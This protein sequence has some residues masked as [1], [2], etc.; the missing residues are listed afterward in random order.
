MKLEIG[1]VADTHGLVRDALVRLL[2]G[3]EMILHAGDVG[4]LDVLDTLRAIAPVQAV[5]GNVDPP[6]HPAMPLTRELRLGDRQIVLTHGHELGRP[7]SNGLLG[8][9][10]DADIII[11]G[12]THQAGVWQVDS[13]VVINPGAAGPRR[14]GVTPSFARLTIDAGTPR[15]AVVPLTFDDG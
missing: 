1:V 13:R 12:H 6:G 8:R 15:V 14:F 9:Y 2:D 5:A 10:P 3:V 7:T 4:T 11:F